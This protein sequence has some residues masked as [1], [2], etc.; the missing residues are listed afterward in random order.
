MGDIALYAPWGNLA[1]FYKDFG[2]ARGLIVLARI[3]TGGENLSKLSGD[4]KVEWME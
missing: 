3:D 1:I 2:Y 4:V